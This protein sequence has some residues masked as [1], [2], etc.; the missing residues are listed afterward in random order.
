MGT[1]SRID[2]GAGGG[3]LG[4]GADGLGGGGLGV[5][6]DGVGGGGLGVG[7]GGAFDVEG[8]A[9]LSSPPRSRNA[10]QNARNISHS[11]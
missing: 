2:T 3:G 10:R 1:D 6:A 5:G 11:T 9:V 7:S 8:A 4:V